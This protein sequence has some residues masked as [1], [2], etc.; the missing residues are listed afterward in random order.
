MSL[1]DLS[2]LPDILV[3]PILRAALTEDLGRAGDITS[4]AVIPAEARMAAVMAA[5]QPGVMAGGTVVALAFRL[6]DPGVETRIIIPDGAAVAPGD[7]VMTIEGPARSVLGAER[8]AL[9]LACRLAGIAT[10]TASLVAAASPHRARIT[11]TRKTTPGLRAL[12]KYAVRAGGGA[13][14]RFGL[15]DAVLI[16]DNHIA[17][18]GG[19]G[20][21][22]RRAR[23]HVGHLV[24]IEV[25]IDHLDQL[26]EVLEAGAD[27]VL[28]DNMTP[29]ELAEAVA[30][31]GGRA[32]T[33][34]SGRI[35]RETVGAVA[36]SGV[37]LISAGWLTHSAPILDLG[38][39]MP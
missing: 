18:A 24:K 19:A 27:A 38:L 28:L 8:V 39:D 25:E 10:A 9:N 34:A 14:H 2:P 4:A 37:D 31:I 5:R 21:A 30:R 35:T 16:K 1:P 29:A 22:I 26:D 15:D 11:C 20:I 32:I 33:E 13:N 7:V 12:E 3:E 17:V 23:A 36:A 6:L